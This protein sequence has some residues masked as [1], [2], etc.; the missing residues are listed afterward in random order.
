MSTAFERKTMPI[1][2]LRI[3]GGTQSRAMILQATVDTY[4]EAMADG[5]EF[6]PVVAFFDGKDYWLADGF[7]RYHA[8]R[9]NKRASIV[10]NVTT[11]TVRDAIL[12]SF[13]A[14]GM[15]GMQMTGDDKRRIVT[16]MLN[17]FEWGQWSDREIA[18]VCHVSHTFVAKVRVETGSAPS[19]VKYKDKSGEVRERTR[20]AKPPKKAEPVL[21]E[22]EPDVNPFESEQAE[23]IKF[24]IGENEKLTDQ[25]AVKGATDPKAAEELIAELRAQIKVLEVEL[26]AVKTSR[27]QFQAE[28]SQMKKQLVSYQRQLKKAA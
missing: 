3:D 23:T 4:A 2:A 16:E 19:K 10:T 9:K 13:G 7:H 15:H 27:D 28:N 1:T 26:A 21:K 20:D 22:K 25:L 14:N 17:D 11:G 5:A 24:L 18:R 6:P 12:Y 8:T